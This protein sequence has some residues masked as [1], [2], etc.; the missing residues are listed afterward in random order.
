MVSFPLKTMNI[1]EAAEAQFRLVDII[2]S[3]FK[4][5]EFLNCGDLGV[6]YGEYPLYTKKVELVLASFFGS[7][8]AVLVRGAGTGAIRSYLSLHLKAGSKVLVHD[9]PVYSTTA[10]TLMDMG[11]ELVKLDFNLFDKDIPKDVD[12]AIVQHSRQKMD[13]KYDIGQVL[14]KIREQCP[15]LPILVDD[16]YTA[17][18]VKLSTI[19]MGAYASAFS[20]FKLLG[21]EGIGCILCSKND[22]DKIRK[23]NYSG[24]SKVQ[25]FE[26]M[27]CLRSLV[28][29]PVAFALQSQEVDKIV[30]ALNSGVVDGVEK[31]VRANA[32]SVV[33]LVKF[34]EPIAKKAIRA[35][36]ELGA[37][38]YPVGA[39]SKY[40]IAAMFYRLSGT[41]ISC[42][43]ALA[44]YA[45]RINPM[46]SG[47]DT[48]ISIL[49][50]IVSCC[51]GE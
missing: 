33:A 28:Y 19:S 45:I 39:E 5:D 24:G 23:R 9:A 8:D 10:D 18:K 29:A 32:Q 43:P 40:E 6:V 4:G 16:N 50:K 26:A 46:R 27:E 47:S 51:K 3:H 36:N 21:K 15:G 41:F 44:D 2:H 34:K 37:A 38:P 49:K 31:A 48:V 35:A 7:E 17:M 1:N 12:M 25:G 42:E 30:E 22:G 13:D 14:E 20:L 11:V